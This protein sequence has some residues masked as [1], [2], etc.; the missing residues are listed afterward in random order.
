LPVLKKCGL[1]GR[2]KILTQAALA[3]PLS[4]MRSGLESAAS[5]HGAVKQCPT[6]RQLQAADPES[7]PRVNTELTIFK[8]ASFGEG[9]SRPDGGL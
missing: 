8:I 3:M 2:L 5:S 9:R 1:E 6:A 4:L 7:H